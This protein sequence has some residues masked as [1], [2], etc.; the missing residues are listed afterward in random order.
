MSQK[1]Y[2]VTVDSAG[3]PISVQLVGAAGELSEVPL[4]VLF[5]TPAAP[6]E[7]VPDPPTPDDGPD[8]AA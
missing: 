6:V 4:S 5:A 7:P 2:L 3:V 8:G 1:R